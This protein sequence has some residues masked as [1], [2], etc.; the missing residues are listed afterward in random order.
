MSILAQVLAAPF[1]FTFLI[2]AFLQ[3]LV[4][5]FLQL[6]CFCRDL[7]VTIAKIESHNGIPHLRNNTKDAYIEEMVWMN[8]QL[9]VSCQLGILR[10]TDFFWLFHSILIS[11]VYTVFIPLVSIQTQ[12]LMSCTCDC[13]PYWQV[14]QIPR[15]CAMFGCERFEGKYQG[16][17]QCLGVKD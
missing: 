9:S 7:Y 4:T 6:G 2:T 12:V 10:R 17:V 14:E 3:L 13:T 1:D 15:T 16:L 5:T 8:D 11:N